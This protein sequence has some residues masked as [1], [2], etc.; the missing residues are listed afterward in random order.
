MAR[1]SKPTKRT[2]RT[3]KPAAA[4]EEQ[5]QMKLLWREQEAARNA[6]RAKER[7]AA[8]K[9]ASRPSLKG[10]RSGEYRLP[11]ELREFLLLIG[12][13]VGWKVKLF[14]A[15]GTPYQERDVIEQANIIREAV[16]EAYLEGCLQGFIEGQLVYR[17]TA[18]QRSNK[19]NAA[20]RSKRIA[21]C[22]KSMTLDERD[23]A[24]A[25]EFPTLKAMVGSMG[26]QLRL[27]EKYG[28]ESREQIANIIRKANKSRVEMP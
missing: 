19:A 5:R 25:T 28:L 26:A 6:T 13:N 14:D 22:G 1:T 21:V 11:Q 3:R 24:I 8:S 9:A 15:D 10:S 4:A 18:Q 23:A 7:A 20:K 17:T 27:A 16:H 2:K 12:P